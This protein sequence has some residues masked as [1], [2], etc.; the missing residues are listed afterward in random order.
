[1]QQGCIEAVIEQRPSA[2][3]LQSMKDSREDA[4]P[5]NKENYVLYYTSIG[6]LT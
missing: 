5:T 3:R 1:M 4:L 6:S 2:L